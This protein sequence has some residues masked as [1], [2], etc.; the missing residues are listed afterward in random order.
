MDMT[1]GLII[2]ALHWAALLSLLL[3][4]RPALSSRLMMVY[5]LSLLFLCIPIAG[6]APVFYLRG[7][8]GEFSLTSTL[9]LIGLAFC[10]VTRSESI[11]L[12]QSELK[13]LA[14]LMALVALWFY[15]MSLGAGIVDPYQ[16]GYQPNLLAI[17]AIAVG[18]LAWAKGHNL[19]V[20]VL[21]LDL[22][23]FQ[24]G[25]LESNNLWDYL[26]DPFAAITALVYATSTLR[27]Q[28]RAAAGQ[29]Q[30]HKHQPIADDG[31]VVQ[32]KGHIL[33]REQHV[34]AGENNPAG[35]KHGYGY[36]EPGVLGATATAKKAK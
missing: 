33:S 29:P 9:V 20:A 25:L 34:V 12:P 6:L 18:V 2:S 23:A 22:I 26:I 14:G 4:R 30:H 21:S 19:I 24:F 27:A 16:W 5:G 3:C 1:P 10:R 8:F 31:R 13:W 32:I 7:V 28:W 15:P 36:T 17:A 35:E 11:H